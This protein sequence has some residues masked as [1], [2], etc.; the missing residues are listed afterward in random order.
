M[1]APRCVLDA[2]AVLAWLRRERGGQAVE[3][4]L[5]HAALSTVN[6][7]EVLCQADKLGVASTGLT[8]ELEA[9][10][11]RFVP[12]T[13]EDAGLVEEVHRTARRELPALSLGGCCCL[14][15]GIRLNLPVVGGDQA[16]EA[17][18]LG[19]DV[20]PIR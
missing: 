9:A 5:G 8:D 2:S 18:R 19:I 6:L 15:T 3:R 1:N 14:A 13:E 10:G 12:F 16:W 11:I 7:A 4:V 20:H 17:L